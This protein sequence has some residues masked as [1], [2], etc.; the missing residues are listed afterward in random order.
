MN[1]IRNKVFVITGSTQGIGKELACQILLLGGKVVFNSRKKEKI[2]LVNDLLNTYTEHCL[3]IAADVTI[4]E[5]AN[6]L[7]LGTIEH[8]GQLDVLINNAGVSGYGQLLES[9][10]VVIEEIIKNNILGSILPTRFALP[11]LLNSKGKVIFISSLAA[12]H[13]LPGYSLY[14]SSKM[15]LTAF[16]QSLKKEIQQKGIFVGITYVGFTKNDGEKK[17]FSPS[18]ALV[19]VPERDKFRVATQEKTARLIINQIINE[20]EIKVH[21]L[22]GKFAYS[23]SRLFP[24]L[25]DRLLLYKYIKSQKV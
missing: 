7:M 20:E 19:K 12:L 9:T 6:L 2:S 5:E 13:G 8:F 14:S 16:Y 17:T 25:L 21:S 23:M 10:P 4:P 24:S 15:A 3:F 22:I 11:Y 18:G 1:K